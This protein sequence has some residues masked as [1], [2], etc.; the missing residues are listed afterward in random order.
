[1]TIKHTLLPV[2]D[3]TLIDLERLRAETFNT[4]PNYNFNWYVSSIQSGR[5]LPFGTYIDNELAAGAIIE[6]SNDVLHIILIF[7]KPK[8]QDSGLKLG[9][10][11]L[12]YIISNKE[13]IDQYYGSVINQVELSYMGKKSHEIYLKVGFQEEATDIERQTHR[14][15]KTI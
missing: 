11:L 6:Q 15:Y 2:N 3:D 8:Y 7:T 10:E 14:M 5:C 13:V 12:N 4:T 9:R 1:M